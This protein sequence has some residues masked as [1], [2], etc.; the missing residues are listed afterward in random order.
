MY[1]TCEKPI[2]LTQQCKT[3]NGIEPD[4]IF[5]IRDMVGDFEQLIIVN[6]YSQFLVINPNQITNE[7]I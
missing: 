1:Q 7:S 6:Q 4:E 3:E 5:T 2:Q